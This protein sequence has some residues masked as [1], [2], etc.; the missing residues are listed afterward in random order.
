MKIAKRQ[1]QHEW[2]SS[3]VDLLIEMGSVREEALYDRLKGAVHVDEAVSLIC[4]HPSLHLRG[5]YVTFEAFAS[6]H[7]RHQ[8][9]QLFVATFPCSLRRVDLHG[10]YRFVDADLDDLVFNGD[11]LVLDVDVFI[12]KPSYIPSSPP[13]IY[14]DCWKQRRKTTFA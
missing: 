9:L 13:A 4:E 14:A 7:C 6:V 3:A 2:L 11:L 5:G 1:L 8:L 12:A 10:L